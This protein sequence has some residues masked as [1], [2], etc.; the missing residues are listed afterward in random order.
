MAEGG[1]GGGSFRAARGGAGSDREME[2]RSAEL[3][4]CNKCVSVECCDC[5]VSYRNNYY[6]VITTNYVKIIT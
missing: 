5:G 6:K 4:C 3:K 1:A 2:Y